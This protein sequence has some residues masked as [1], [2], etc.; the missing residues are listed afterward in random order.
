[1]DFTEQIGKLLITIGNGVESFVD[2][3]IN[4]PT[5]F[6]NLIDLIPEPLYVIINSFIGFLIFVIF[7]KVVRLIVG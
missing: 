2:F 3:L 5:L 1:M 7:L 4:L 6:Y